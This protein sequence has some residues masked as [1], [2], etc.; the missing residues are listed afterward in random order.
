MYLGKKVDLLI[1]YVNFKDTKWQADYEKVAKVRVNPGMMERFRSFGTLRYLL[2]GVDKFMPY[3]DRVILIVAY[4]T[5]VP[6]WVN[7][8]N[9]TI[10]THDKFIPA[11]HLPT[12]N[13][14]TIESQFHRIS[15]LNPY[16]IYTNDDIYPVMPSEID[17]FY[18]Q[19]L[20]NT[21]FK[22]Y[23]GYSKEN[24]FRQQCKNGADLIYSILKKKR[25]IDDTKV[26][27]TF[28][29]PD[30]CM[31]ALTHE[32]LKTVGYLCGDELRK[33]STAFRSLK[34]INQHIYLYYQYFTDKY[35]D[36]VIDYKYT[37]FSDGIDSV[38]NDIL[39]PEHKFLCLNDSGLLSDQYEDAK[40]KVQHALRKRLPDACK[41][42]N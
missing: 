24:L 1:T 9:V 40:M 39:N 37:T 33:I 6:K 36:K 19:S 38:C 20:P 15:G 5:Q 26:N 35:Y 21:H 11:T 23:R 27:P 16:I 28:F 10:I 7:R 8:N 31:S 32:T 42:E 30:H 22:F 34:N 12:F 13:S 17:D 29:K 14:C 18:T 4:E 41:Y 25:L 3:V 2:R